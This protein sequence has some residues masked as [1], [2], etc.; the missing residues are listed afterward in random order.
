[1][2]VPSK[3]PP[4]TGNRQFDSLIPLVLCIVG[5]YK[6]KT[7]M[8]MA[9]LRGEAFLSIWQSI[10]LG[11]D[12]SQIIFHLHGDLAKACRK[13]KKRQPKHSRAAY[14]EYKPND[15]EIYFSVCKNKRERKVVDM[16]SKGYKQIE[17][18]SEL[19]CSAATVNIVIDSLRDRYYEQPSIS[20]AHVD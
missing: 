16:L 10:V 6:K 8:E 14:Y 18:A 7:S 17:I 4:R 2:A 19:Q 11:R 12:E 13:E 20:L 3:L 5:Q 15:L 9:D 1:M